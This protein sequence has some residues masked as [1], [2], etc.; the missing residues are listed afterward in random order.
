MPAIAKYVYFGLL[1]VIPSADALCFP[2]ARDTLMALTVSADRVSA[3]TVCLSV[4]HCPQSTFTRK[5]RAQ[6][7]VLA[8]PVSSHAE[9]P[10]LHRTCHVTHEP[11]RQTDR[12]T[13]RHQTNRQMSGQTVSERASVSAPSR[14]F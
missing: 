9:H 12:Q 14:H 8:A 7:C 3:L 10:H 1:Q 2:T 11:V 4:Y 13:D 5:Y 6:S